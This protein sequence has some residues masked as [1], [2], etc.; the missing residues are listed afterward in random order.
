[1]QRVIASFTRYDTKKSCFDGRVII[2]SR[3][4]IILL[5]DEIWKY[6]D[7]QVMRPQQLVRTPQ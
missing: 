1:M 4:S 7:L 2:I 5:F 3:K 6:T